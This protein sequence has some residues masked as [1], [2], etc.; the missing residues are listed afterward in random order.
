MHLTQNSALWPAFTR[1]QRHPSISWFF[2]SVIKDWWG[3]GEGSRYP[4]PAPLT[5]QPK[6][7]WIELS[8]QCCQPILQVRTA[9]PWPPFIHVGHIHRVP[10][11][12]YFLCNPLSL[13]VPDTLVVRTHSIP[14]QQLLSGRCLACGCFFFSLLTLVIINMA[15][16]KSLY[17]AE[18]AIGQILRS[19][20][21]GS[22]IQAFTIC[23]YCDNWFCQR[24]KSGINVLI[25]RSWEWPC[26]SVSCSTPNVTKHCHLYQYKCENMYS[27][28][29]EWC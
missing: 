15:E 11:P 3:W 6:Q 13:P 28:N 4:A 2:K 14:F 22:W 17:T 10:R 29:D 24:K 21:S 20:K 26:V 16:V 25:T 23:I 27:F 12:L 8:P 19:V 5:L 1:N 7:S 18:V 9:L